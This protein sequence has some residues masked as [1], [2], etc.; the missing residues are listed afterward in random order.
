MNPSSN[1]L[2]SLSDIGRVEETGQ[3]R[4]IGAQMLLALARKEI[5][6]T[7]LEAGAKMV[8]AQ[9]AH[10]AAECRLQRMAAEMRAAGGGLG[11]V[12]P[13]GK[14]RIDERGEDSAN[15]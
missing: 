2:E 13:L 3:V 1:T 14:L 12:K 7:D 9:A 15:A 6:A 5:S 11:P 10:M 4:R 8:L